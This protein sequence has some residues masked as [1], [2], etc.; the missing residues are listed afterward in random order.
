MLIGRF[1]VENPLGD[2][3]RRET[4]LVL[5]QVSSMKNVCAGQPGSDDAA[6]V[7]GDAVR[8][9]GRVPRRLAASQYN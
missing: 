6:N 1:V 4:L 5:M 8:P 7:P 3:P 9:S 2:H